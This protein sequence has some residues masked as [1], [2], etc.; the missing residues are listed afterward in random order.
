MS[1]YRIYRG[2]GGVE[3]ID[4]DHPVACLPPGQARVELD[5]ALAPGGRAVFA[6]RAMS[7]DGVEEHNT[8]AVAVVEI[9]PDGHLLGAALAAPADVTAEAAGAA[10]I[11]LGFTYAPPAGGDWPDRFEILGDGGTGQFALDHPLA[12]VP[13]VANQADYEAAI[14]RP[15]TGLNLAVRACNGA[16][17]GPLS[18]TV[19]IPAPS[20]PAPALC[21]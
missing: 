16:V 19:S 1:Q 18:H 13:A 4:W 15:A 20:S 12:T 8:Y 14:P 2:S 5:V 6:A 9:G 11:V 10:R 21:L 17:A 7:D 3:S